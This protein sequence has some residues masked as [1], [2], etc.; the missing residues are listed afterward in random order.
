MSLTFTV[1]SAFSELASSAEEHKN[2]S[3]PQDHHYWSADKKCI[4]TPKL[5]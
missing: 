5:I 2:P 4:I 3:Y 1:A